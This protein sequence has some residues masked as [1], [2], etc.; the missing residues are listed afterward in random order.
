M[1]SDQIIFAGVRLSSG[2][3]PVTIAALD[4]DLNIN[5]LERRDVSETLSRL[6]EFNH[7]I[8]AINNLNSK[9]EQELHKDFI[10]KI[11]QAGFEF[12]S[13]DNNTKQWFETNVQDCFR[14]VS[15]RHLLSRST[16]GGRLQR[17]LVLYEQGL[18]INDPMD[19]FEEITRY[20]L[21]QGILPFDNIY[22]SRELD[23][24]VLAYLAWMALN[25]PGQIVL[26]GEFVLP[27]RE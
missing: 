26:Q 18:Q 25:R 19:I 22:S 7:V 5:F 1:P 4:D 23:A 9:R 14:V 2:R 24:L 8:L 27:A 3:K 17:A 20:K 13:K 21:M 16:L 6:E 12:Y 15:G 10:K 11:I